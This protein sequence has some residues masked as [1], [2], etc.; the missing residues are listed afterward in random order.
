MEGT[1]PSLLLTCS[2]RCKDNHLLLLLYQ[3]HTTIHHSLPCA[4][5]AVLAGALGS[6]SKILIVSCASQGRGRSV[7]DRGERGA[8]ADMQIFLQDGSSFKGDHVEAKKPLPF[9]IL[10]SCTSV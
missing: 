4:G 7:V 3:Q 5:S 6:G 1:I 8:V 2:G 9:F 10:C